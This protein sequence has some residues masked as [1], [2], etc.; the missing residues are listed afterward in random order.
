MGL[1][2][3]ISLTSTYLVYKSYCQEEQYCNP[4]PLDL[5]VII[6][7]VARGFFDQRNFFDFTASNFEA[8]PKLQIEVV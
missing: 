1:P 3:K 8:S 4:H 7:H 5:N 2:L 6:E